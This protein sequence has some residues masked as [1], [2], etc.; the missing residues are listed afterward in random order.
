MET[1]SRARLDWPAFSDQM[2]GHL[3]RSVGFDGWCLAQTDPATL[4]PAR[5][6]TENSPAEACQQRLWQ[7][8]HHVPDFNKL[9]SLAR[10][11]RPVRALREATGG[12][13]ARSQRWQDIMRPADVGDELRAALTTGGYCW[14]SLTLYRASACPFTDEDI[15]FL[16]H[17][18]SAAA[19]GARG[20]WTVRNRASDA[21]TADGPGTI[22]ATAAG[23]PLTTTPQASRWLARLTPSPR[24]SQAIIYALTTLLAAPATGTSTAPAARVRARTA[25]GHWLDIHAAPLAAAV[26]GC[27]VAITVQPAALG[28][29]STLLMRAYALS[30]REREIAWLILNGRTPTEIAGGLHISLYTAKDHIK[31]IFRKTGTHSRPELTQCLTGRL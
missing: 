9:A 4:L 26:P 16:T 19:A 25:D 1:L 23:T 28:L 18:L 5:A 13:L 22:I 6:A 10:G 15:Q 29:I 20:T 11:D 21:I 27:E 2:A 17:L 3:R 30:E 12:D 31:A 7:I 24:A 14:G 8:E